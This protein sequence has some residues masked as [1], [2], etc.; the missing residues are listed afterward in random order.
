MV[1]KCKGCES[2]EA[3]Y[4][5]FESGKPFTE[6]LLQTDRRIRHFT[7]DTPAHLLKWHADE[8]DRV[9]KA[10]KLTDWQF[11]FDNELPIKLSVNTYISIQKG[12]IHRLIKGETDLY[13]E[14]MINA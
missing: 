1:E 7:N 11:Q 14:I 5:S 2:K 3:F 12:R 13:I 8:E 4:D 10:H 9:I 6:I